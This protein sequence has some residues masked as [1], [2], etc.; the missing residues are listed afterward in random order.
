MNL[1]NWRLPDRYEDMGSIVLDEIE[2]A[3]R[4]IQAACPGMWWTDCNPVFVWEQ[5]HPAIRSGACLWWERGATYEVSDIAPGLTL[6]EFL[7]AVLSQADIERAVREREPDMPLLME[8]QAEGAVWTMTAQNALAYWRWLR[9]MERA[10]LAR[11]QER[12]REHFM[13]SLNEGGVPG[14]ETF[15]VPPGVSF[16]AP[17]HEELVQME[18]AQYVAD[19]WSGEESK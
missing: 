18:D 13:R 1:L 2:G 10:G 8:R 11:E 3:W 9:D 6:D 7:S 5:M 4:G 15:T 17:T 16:E 14:E 12:T 19:L